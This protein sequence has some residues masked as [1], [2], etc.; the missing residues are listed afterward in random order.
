M[1]R[2]AVTCNA[3]WWPL[4]G[5]S[6]DHAVPKETRQDFALLTPSSERRRREYLSSLR[7]PLRIR[8]AGATPCSAPRPGRIDRVPK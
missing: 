7:I 4:G 2:S 8:G 1:T 5:N 3:G 6:P